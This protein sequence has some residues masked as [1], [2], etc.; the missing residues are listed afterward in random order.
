[1]DSKDYFEFY[2]QTVWKV[3]KKLNTDLYTHHKSGGVYEDF[4]TYAKD[5]FKD[6]TSYEEFHESV[7]KQKNRFIVNDD[8]FQ[9]KS[10]L[11]QGL[12]NLTK[13][14]FMK[15]YINEIIFNSSEDY[16]TAFIENRFD[17]KTPQG[18]SEYLISILPQMSY[19]NALCYFSQVQRWQEMH[20]LIDNKFPLI[21][22]HPHG[23]EF[24]FVGL[25]NCFLQ[26]KYGMRSHS[27]D[28]IIKF[29]I[30]GY[31]DADL[32]TFDFLPNIESF[33]LS[34]TKSKNIVIN[35]DEIFFTTRLSIDCQHAM[36]IYYTKDSELGHYLYLVEKLAEHLVKDKNN[37]IFDINTIHKYNEDKYGV[38]KSYKISEFFIDTPEHEPNLKLRLSYLFNKY[39]KDSTDALK[40]S[41]EIDFEKFT[42]NWLLQENLQ[43][44]LITNQESKPK[45][46]KL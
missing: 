41:Q 32:Q 46:N 26:D 31:S 20:I 15:E 23:K 44:E 40:A 5:E 42:E 34:K 30:D 28:S 29:L 43:S 33:L 2:L 21:K 22:E 10:S 25:K 1:M 17:Y 35:D 14:E 18:S 7:M 19:E 27:Y 24:L 45:V 38:N 11:F 12:R 8:Y 6:I 13:D 39:I 37:N 9:I 36:N 4:P 3:Y 16:S